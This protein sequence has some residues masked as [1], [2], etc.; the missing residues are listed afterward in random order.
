MRLKDNIRR[1]IAAV[2]T[3][4][5]L[6]GAMTVY[7]D[8]VVDTPD[9]TVFDDASDTESSDGRTEEPG[10]ITDTENSDDPGNPDASDTADTSGEA[11]EEELQSIEEPAEEELLEAEALVTDITSGYYTVYSALGTNMVMDVGAASESDD[12]KID[13]YK[14]N[15]SY[16]QT[17]YINNKGNGLYTIRSSVSDKVLTSGKNPARLTALRQ[18]AATD[19][20]E[21]L[22]KI[23]TSSKS[24]YYSIVSAVNE[25]L[26]IDVEGASSVNGA[27]LRLY[28]RKDYDAQRW[29]FGTTTNSA[30]KT[31]STL[32][33]VTIEK[34]E[35]VIGSA[36]AD[37]MVLDVEAGSTSNFANIDLYRSNNT[38]AQI[39]EITPVSK[40]VYAVINKGSGK[41]VDVYAASTHQGANVDQYK[42]NGTKAQL[43]Y[44]KDNGDGTY[45]FKSAK[46]DKVMTAMGSSNFSNVCMNR[47]AGAKGQKWTI[48]KVSSGTAGGNTSEEVKTE[49][50]TGVYTISMNSDSSMC[51]DI[52]AGSDSNG[53]NLQVYKSNKTQAQ[54][55]YI[56]PSGDGHYI[57]TN[58]C[59]RKV[60]TVENSKAASGTNVSQAVYSGQT[61]QKW[62][63]IRNSDGSYNIISVLGNFALDV[64]GGYTSNGT[65]VWIYKK[66]GSSAQK[67]NIIES[68]VAAPSNGGMYVIRCV[69]DPYKVLDVAASSV[70]NL[71]NVQIYN[72]N[73][74]NAQ[75]W[76]VVNK[77]NFFALSNVCSGKTLDV[78][79]G[80]S[81]DGANV[82]QYTYNA[83]KAQQWQFEATGDPDGSF[84]IKNANGK[85]LDIASGSMSS[86][87]NVQVYTKSK[88][89]AQKF[90]ITK[91]SSNYSGWYTSLSGERY[92][93]VNG[94]TVKSAWKTIGAYTYYFNSSGVMAKNTIVDNYNIDSEGR[95]TTRISDSVNIGTSH[96]KTLKAYLKN[97]LLPIGKCLYI[98]GGGHGDTDASKIGVLASWQDFY[99]EHSSKSYDYTQYRW[100]YGKG[101]DCSGYAGWVLYNTVFTKDGGDWLAYTSTETYSK[102]VSKGWATDNGKS[103]S[104][105]YPGD[106]VSMNGHVWISL[107]QCS[108][109]SVVLVHCTPD[110]GVQISGTIVPSTGSY[111]SQA[112]TLANQYMKKYFPEWY[113]TYSVKKEGSGY[114]KNLAGVAH[115]R[116]SGGL[117][118]DPDGIQKM[119]ANQVL[120][121][122]LGSV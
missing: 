65:N 95:R 115:W 60:L 117:L 26:A 5:M 4:A 24:G 118:S 108:D 79:A 98:W 8:E 41:A 94:S 33:N 68:T 81:A 28:D 75:K 112:I 54:Q 72:Q 55:Y 99:K 63:F 14:S 32:K 52:A 49:M 61:G 43:F 31:L 16:A 38:K 87:T 2:L 45:T 21:Q 73:N 106:V 113:S 12:A 97:S 18:T 86:G 105:F 56:K 107:G 67:F 25:E 69:D 22:W 30:L 50:K 37:N 58:V 110:G 35:Y 83:T 85:Y 74:T 90:Y 64:Y 111:S 23:Y 70:D 3:A 89:R 29:K 103:P 47:F 34:G 9:S 19:A 46:G 78:Y 42:Y 40:S 6:C 100:Q 82:D 51:L 13:I 84:Y 62:D 88:S 92:Y 7:A 1:I 57:I 114:I 15:N 10:D 91:T 66:N 104:K 71:A 119:S 102:Y 101:L 76:W 121:L 93:Y 122:L 53:A 11:S 80:S 77:G 116:T 17:F 44:I 39:F 109:G 48:K 59:T 27:K 96:D 20:D 120:K 36:L